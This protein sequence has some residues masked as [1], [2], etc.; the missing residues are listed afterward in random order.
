[1]KQPLCR[2]CGVKIK[3]Q[4]VTAF[5]GRLERRNNHRFLRS[6]TEKPATKS[7]LQALTNM[8]IVFLRWSHDREFIEQASLWDGESY[9]SKFFCTDKH[10]AA[11]GYSAARGGLGTDDYWKKAGD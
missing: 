5:F 10:A 3:K 4:T 2:Y 8:E 1:M 11:L 7:Q 6:Y 9:T